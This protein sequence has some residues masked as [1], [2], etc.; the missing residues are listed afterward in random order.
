[1][2]KLGLDKECAYEYEYRVNN[3]KNWRNRN[4]TLKGVALHARVWEDVSDGSRSVGNIL[5]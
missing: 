2:K 5:S 4:V 3:T 1:M